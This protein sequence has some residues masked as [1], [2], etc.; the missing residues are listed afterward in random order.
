M[1]RN[2]PTDRAEVADRKAA[3]M[4]RNVYGFARVHRFVNGWFPPERRHAIM[5][6]CHASRAEAVAS[7]TIP[8]RL[9]ASLRRNQFRQRPF[10]N[11]DNESIDAPPILCE[12]QQQ[13]SIGVRKP[14]FHDI[15]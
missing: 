14:V 5:Y 9:G 3:F 12:R 1:I 6:L 7:L 4:G 2:D 15:D 11:Q 13:T 10:I 8:H